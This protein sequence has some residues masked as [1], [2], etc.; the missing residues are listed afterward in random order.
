MTFQNPTGYWEHTGTYTVKLIKSTD[1]SDLP[2]GFDIDLNTMIVTVMN[3]RI[4]KS[5]GGII[6][7]HDRFGNSF[8]W[9]YKFLIEIR[10]G[11]GKIIWQNRNHIT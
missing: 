5:M 10:D 8:Y 1:I 2:L 6:Q 11:Q 3:G 9:G 7:L 4:I